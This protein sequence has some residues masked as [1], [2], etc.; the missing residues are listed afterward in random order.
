[1]TPTDKAAYASGNPRIRLRTRL[2][3]S[4]HT[5]PSYEDNEHDIAARAYFEKHGYRP[6]TE[7]Q[8]NAVTL[9]GTVQSRRG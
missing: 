1:M 9:F 7:A 8:S 5:P 4:K 2:R 3:N 6:L